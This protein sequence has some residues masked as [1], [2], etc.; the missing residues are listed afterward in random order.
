MSKLTLLTDQVGPWKMNSYVLID[1]DTNQSI[2]F[3]PG[4]SPDKLSAMLGDSTPSA[5]VLTH[6]H[7]DHIMALDEMRKK[8]G[9]PLRLHPGPHDTTEDTHVVG[10]S[11]LNDGDT[12]QLGSHTLR[13]VYAPGH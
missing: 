6:T 3:D 7:I 10:D 9:V 12:L 5:I 11:A 8:L 4:G 1:P 13:A 2:L